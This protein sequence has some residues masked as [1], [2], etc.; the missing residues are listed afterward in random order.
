MLIR[1]RAVALLILVCLGVAV[2]A[3]AQVSTEVLLSEAV[4]SARFAPTE[5]SREYEELIREHARNNDVRPGLVLAVIQVESASN[6]SAVSPKGGIGLMQLVPA[7]IS[8]F[9]GRDP[10]GPRED[11]R[12]GGPHLWH[13]RAP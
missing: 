13:L 1:L 7:T 5:R 11:V 12:A 10:F 8:Q 9:G 3:S 4:R 2:T 6:P